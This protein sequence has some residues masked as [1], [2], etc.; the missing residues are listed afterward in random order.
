MASDDF[1]VVREWLGAGGVADFFL[2]FSYCVDGAAFPCFVWE[3]RN[4]CLVGF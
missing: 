3:L 2:A 4:V 1:G